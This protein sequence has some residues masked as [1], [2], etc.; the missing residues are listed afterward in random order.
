MNT[1]TIRI[2]TL[3]LTF[4]QNKLQYSKTIKCH[5]AEYSLFIVILNIVM[6]IVIVLIV[7]ILSVII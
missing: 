3:R 4:K 6:L 5:Y 1:K 7:I 2:T